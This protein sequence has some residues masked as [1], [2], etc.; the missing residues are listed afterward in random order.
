MG[1]IESREQVGH[2][3][4]S[5][6]QRKSEPDR[7]VF[8]IGSLGEINHC[9]IDLRQ[10][11]THRG[12]EVQCRRR[13]TDGASARNGQR[14]PEVAFEGADTSAHRGLGYAERGRGLG[15]VPAPIGQ[16]DEFSQRRRRG[17]AG[18]G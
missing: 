1:P 13:Q 9:R 11:G 15:Q 6:R 2:L 18:I 3:A 16:F 8:G 14:H 17:R 10:R 7:A 4:G 5:H 12:H